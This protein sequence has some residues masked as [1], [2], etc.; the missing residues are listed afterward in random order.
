LIGKRLFLALLLASAMGGAGAVG[1]SQEPGIPVCSGPALPDGARH[2]SE[3]AFGSL[4]GLDGKPHRL[5]D[6]AGQVLLV[7]FWAGW[8]GPCQYE[9]P[10]LAAFQANHAGQGLQVLG[11]GVDRPRR[12]A[13][14][15]RSLEIN[16]PVLMAGEGPGSKLMADWGNR[17]GTLPYTVVFDK[18]GCVAHVRRTVMDE[19][20]LE[21]TV[22]PLLE[23]T[24]T[25]PPAVPQSETDPAP[26]LS[27][28]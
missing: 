1:S 6:W 5:G 13:N 16:Y 11:I 3:L 27:P 23:P 17:A 28:H 14:V 2:L 9:I 22:T 10:D 4:P 15:A 21:D 20:E 8:C 7:N 24:P 25:A 18:D 26:V 19:Q 12:L